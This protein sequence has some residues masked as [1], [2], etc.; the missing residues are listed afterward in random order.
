MAAADKVL[1]KLRVGHESQLLDAPLSK[2]GA[3]HTH[4]WTV[5][6]R[7]AEGGPLDSRLLQKAVFALHPDFPNPNRGSF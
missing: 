3:L 6:V 5:F 1:L 4:R 7:A 2:Q